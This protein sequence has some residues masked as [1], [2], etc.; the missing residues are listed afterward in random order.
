MQLLS[1]A[2]TIRNQQHCINGS[3]ILTLARQI[4]LFVTFTIIEINRGK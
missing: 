2:K 4:K 1:P 3:T